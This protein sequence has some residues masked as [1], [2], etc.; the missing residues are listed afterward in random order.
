VATVRASTPTTPTTPQNWTKQ[1]ALW[2]SAACH[3]S[4][5]SYQLRVALALAMENPQIA[6]TF[7]PLACTGATIP[8]GILGSQAARE[9]NCDLGLRRTPC[10]RQ[11]QGQLEHPECASCQR[12]PA[13]QEPKSG[14]GAVIDWRKRHGFSGPGRQC[15][16]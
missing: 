11:V 14:S 12:A 1:R 2:M 5:Y 4:L 6:V 16:D 15:D 7:I 13:Q 9:N 10:A 8:A 3:R